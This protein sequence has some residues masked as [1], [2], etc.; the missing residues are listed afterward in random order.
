MPPEVGH[1]VGLTQLSLVWS[2]ITTLPDSI[3]RLTALKELELFGNPELS[4]PPGLTACRQLTRLHTVAWPVSPVLPRLLSLRCLRTDITFE[5]VTPDMGWHSLTALTNLQLLSGLTNMLS[6]LSRTTWTTSL[7]KLE[8][9]GAANN[10][11]PTGPYQSGLESLHWDN[12]TLDRVPSGLAAAAQLRHLEL[13]NLY[14]GGRLGLTA[15]DVAV[16]SSMPALATLRLK[17]PRGMEQHVWDER[18]EQLQ[19]TVT[20]LGRAPPVLLDHE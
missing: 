19:A 9:Y 15:A 1:L 16:L 5:S 14:A 18:V 2:E 17:K 10:G 6:E 20:S 13:D 12:Y 11:L 4:L 7:R 3:S 8:I